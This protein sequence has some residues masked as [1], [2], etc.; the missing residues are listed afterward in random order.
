MGADKTSRTF[1]TKTKGE[2]EGDVRHQNILNTFILRPSLI[3][4]NRDEKRTLEKIG[5]TLFKAI[6]PLLIGS[7]KKYR[8]IHAE[9]IA[10][11]MI[12]LA[13]TTA[14]NDV[15]ITSNQIENLGT[16]S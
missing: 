9:T 8:I 14:K 5:L 4:G 11:A 2:M 13:N 7:L 15:I 12:Y 3:G 6:Q 16:N 1:Y 10:N